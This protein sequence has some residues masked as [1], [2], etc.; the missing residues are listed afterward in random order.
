REKVTGRAIYASDVVVP[1]MVHARVV[2]SDVAHARL[3]DVD[4]RA[5]LEQPGVLAVLTGVDVA[6]LPCPRYGHIF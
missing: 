5:A 4:V 6:W 1:G 2:R 3:V